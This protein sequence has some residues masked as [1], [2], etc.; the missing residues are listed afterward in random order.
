M[1]TVESSIEGPAEVAGPP[2]LLVLAFREA[3]RVARHPATWL[4][5][6][7]AALSIGS[8]AATATTRFSA[9]SLYDSIFIAVAALG[10]VAAIFAADLVATSARRAR[11]EEM[12]RA[13]PT[14]ETERTLALCLGVAFAFGGIGLACAAVMTLV[15]VEGSLAIHEVQ[16]NGE[17]AQIPPIV[18]AG[19]L[20]GVLTARWLR[21]PGAVLVTVMVFVVGGTLLSDRLEA[22]SPARYWFPWTTAA[23]LLYEGPAPTGDPR[24]HAP[25]LLGLCALATVLA[26]FRDRS[27]W[28]K[29]V[30]V[31]VPVIALIAVFGVLQLP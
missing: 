25:Y 28:T 18:A 2:R 24:W 17:L 30:A 8:A 6:G 27:Q 16:T 11:A 9:S 15:E 7:V 10:P 26:V 12:L 23:P 20:L 13:T 5:L 3:R 31:A 22:T 1:I 21:F 29:L 19:G 14:P 4:P